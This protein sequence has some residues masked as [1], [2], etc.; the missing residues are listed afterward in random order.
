MKDFHFGQEYQILL[1]RCP[2][3]KCFLSLEIVSLFLFCG[4]VSELSQTDLN[5][6]R[7]RNQRILISYTVFMV[8]S[9]YFRHSH[10]Q[11]QGHA[12]ILGLFKA[13]LY[14]CHFHSSG[15]EKLVTACPQ[16]RFSV[17]LCETLLRKV[18]EEVGVWIYLVLHVD[19]HFT[20]T[21]TY[22]SEISKVCCCSDH[23]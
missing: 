20:I 1:S 6:E 3:R 19:Q 23:A 22:L 9:L 7:N 18:L 13:H 10:L 5:R 17:T 15:G 14:L 8:Y 16:V 4:H 2:C 11:R 12:V 21:T